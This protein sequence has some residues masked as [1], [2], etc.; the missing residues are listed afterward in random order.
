MSG[1]THNRLNQIKTK[2]IAAEVKIGEI[3]INETDGSLWSK[4]TNGNIIVVGGK[5]EIG[6]PIQGE[7]I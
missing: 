5:E 2:P 6:E 4:D 1:V 3:I 7:I